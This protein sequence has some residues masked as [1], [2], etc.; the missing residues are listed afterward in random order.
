VAEVSQKAADASDG[1]N[2]NEAPSAHND[3]GRVERA[4]SIRPVPPEMYDLVLRR[5]SW[6]TRTTFRAASAKKHPRVT[7]LWLSS[8]ELAKCSALQGS[9]VGAWQ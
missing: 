3:R 5:S 7:V 6:R 2:R 4:D 8:T 1:E 9:S